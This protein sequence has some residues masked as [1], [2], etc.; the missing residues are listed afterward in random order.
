MDPP[1]PPMQDSRTPSRGQHTRTGQRTARRNG[2]PLRGPRG[3][4]IVVIRQ[5][6][7]R[8]RRGGSHR[9]VASPSGSLAYEAL[10]AV[11][12]D[13]GRVS[14]PPPGGLIHPLA[15]QSLPSQ[16]SSPVL[17]SIRERSPSGSASETVP[18]SRHVSRDDPGG[19]ARTVTLTSVTVSWTSNRG[20]ALQDSTPRSI[21]RPS[22]DRC[23]S[24]IGT[25]R[26]VEHA[27]SSPPTPRATDTASARTVHT[28]TAALPDGRPI[29][30]RAER[31]GIS[32]PFRQVVQPTED[33]AYRRCIVRA[34][35][36]TTGGESEGLLSVGGEGGK[37]IGAVVGAANSHDDGL[38][39]HCDTY[40]T[41]R[42]ALA[43]QVG[44]WFRKVT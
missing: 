19:S 31:S 25:A 9:A 11:A 29:R 8:L 34:V 12:V 15:I 44:R 23:A 38:G 18:P 39:C 10:M 5:W 7:G 36:D 24:R 3:R 26:A 33:A 37:L 32:A 40:V 30:E 22:S 2:R 17:P 14:G 1:T 20:W 35:P 28:G 16:T 41:R 43:G 13:N 21:E 4:C 27:E 42:D 6:L